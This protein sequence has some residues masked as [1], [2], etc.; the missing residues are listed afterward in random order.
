MNDAPVRVVIVLPLA[1]LR[2]GE[3]FAVERWPLH[4]TVVPPF[5]S[6]V[7]ADTVADAVRRVAAETRPL[8]V[9]VGAAALFGRN[10]DVPVHLVEPHA[11]LSA[12][13]AQ[14]LEAVEGYATRPL[15][16]RTFAPHVTVKQHARVTPGQRLRIDQVAVVDMAP[17]SHPHGRRVL[18]TVPLPAGPARR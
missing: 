5:T 4:I 12:F 8:G 9:T 10:E 2:A 13:R 15:G 6:L 17:R 7:S 16:T 18:A 3:S 1:P 11:G 14:L